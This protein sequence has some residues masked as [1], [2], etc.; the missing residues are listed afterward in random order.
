MTSIRCQT[1]PYWEPYLPEG[2]G[3]C[4]FPTGAPSRQTEAEDPCRIMSKTESD[5]EVAEFFIRYRMKDICRL[6][7]EGV[8]GNTVECTDKLIA[9]L[10]LAREARRI[11]FDATG[12]LALER[13]FCRAI[14]IMEDKLEHL[15]KQEKN[16]G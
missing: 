6:A 9:A 11:A 1:C 8:M 7:L 4:W 5:D 10:V 16:N 3:F 2:S 15:R 14:S 12:S 13:H